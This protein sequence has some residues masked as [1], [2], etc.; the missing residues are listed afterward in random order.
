MKMFVYGSLKKGFHNNP[1]LGDSEFI[2]V[3]I[4]EGYSMADLGA[5]PMA[6]SDPDGEIIGELYY[7][8]PETLEELDRLESEGSYY[9]RELADGLVYENFFIYVASPHYDK[10]LNKQNPLRMWR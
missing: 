2:G 10:R 6:Y 8:T 7:I 3:D 5:Y 9:V 1:V 4:V